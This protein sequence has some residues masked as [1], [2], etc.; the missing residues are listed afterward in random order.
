[1]SEK[2]NKQVVKATKWSTLSE[3]VAKLIVPITSMVLARLLTPEAFGVVT[4]LAMIT[5]FAGL[6]TDAG[7]YNYIV[8]HEFKDDTDCLQ[9]A[10]VAFWSNFIMSIIVWVGI[11]LFADPLADLVGSPGLGHVLSIASLSIPISSLSCIQSALFKRSFDFKTLFKVR[12]VSVLIPLVTTIPLA[13]W[14]RNYWAIVL[15]GLINSIIGAILLITYSHWRPSFYYSFF[16]L[17]KMLSFSIWS[18]V[19]S[20]SIWLTL[21]VDVFIVGTMLN[22]Y[23]L[24]L[25][26]TS[27]TIG[28]SI[29]SLVTAS[30]TPVLF[31]SLSRLQNNEESFNQLFFKF[32]KLVGMLVIPISVGVFCFNDL[33]TAVLL[34]SQWTEAAGFIGLWGLTG[35]ITVVLSHYASE[36]YRAKGHPKLSVLSQWLHIIAIW[37]VVLISVKYGF[38]VLYIS[39]TVV[40]LQGIIVDL[41]IMYY[42]VHILTSQM[43]K[44][45][46]PSVV[47]SIPIFF[48]SYGIR[49]ID[50]G[51]IFQL[52][53]ILLCIIIYVV[54]LYQFSTERNVINAFYIK[55]R[56]IIK[57]RECYH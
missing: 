33:V 39:R 46:L 50:N 52:F 19:E 3:I 5:S 15:G 7:F 28:G 11:F 24:G 31:V 29:L 56:T 49:I 51:L 48:I 35:G 2:I 44:N 22:Q 41:I 27:L 26:K 13:I 34:G 16:K 38:E 21:Y 53:A 55:I 18:Q 12:F 1:M 30:T 45:I 17:R 32:Q 20:I 54:G 8:Q 10:N 57:E 23:Y 36:V 37:P 42:Y 9:S 40:R 43:I 47:S 14:L 6:F 4:T 25:Y